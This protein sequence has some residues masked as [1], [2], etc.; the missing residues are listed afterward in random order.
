MPANIGFQGNVDTVDAQT[1]LT[2]ISHDSGKEEEDE[3]KKWLKVR[4][5]YLHFYQTLIQ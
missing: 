2:N 4:L 5:Q 1:P 3:L